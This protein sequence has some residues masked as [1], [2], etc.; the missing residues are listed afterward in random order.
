MPVCLPDLMV[1]EC[2][3]GS[4]KPLYAGFSRPR[5]ERPVP[6]RTLVGVRR[7]GNSKIENL[8]GNPRICSGLGLTA[9]HLGKECGP[10]RSG[11]SEYGS[12]LARHME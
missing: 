11:L 1:E 8:Q 4:T 3:R 6:W 12:A 7:G 9:R 10:F 5:T 2:F